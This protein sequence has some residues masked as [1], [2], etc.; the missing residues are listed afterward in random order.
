[1][2]RIYYDENK[3]KRY[4]NIYIYIELKILIEEKKKK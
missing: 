4:D 1:M 2:I 3:V